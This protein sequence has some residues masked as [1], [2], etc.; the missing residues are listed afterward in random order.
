MGEG[1]PRNLGKLDHHEFYSTQYES[2]PLTCSALSS[3]FIRYFPLLTTEAVNCLKWV[4][5]R[6]PSLKDAMATATVVRG[7]CMLSQ[8]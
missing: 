4:F 6:Y 1:Y 8:N 3:G 2:F 5:S 7:R